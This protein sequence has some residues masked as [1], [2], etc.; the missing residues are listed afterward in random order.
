MLQSVRERVRQRSGWIYLSPLDL[1]PLLDLD[2]D[3]FPD[4]RPRWLVAWSVVLQ[5]EKKIP[6][7]KTMT[8][9][10]SAGF[11]RGFCWGFCSGW[12]M[13]ANLTADVS[14]KVGSE[15]LQKPLRLPEGNLWLCDT[16]IVPFWLS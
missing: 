9:G 6:V 4:G 11:G 7:E 8:Y 5:A 14:W 1:E 15:A 2:P 3:G 13:N 10:G 12:L 16:E